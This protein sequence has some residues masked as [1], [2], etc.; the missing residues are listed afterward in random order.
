MTTEKEHTDPE[1]LTEDDL[2]KIEAGIGGLTDIKL[3]SVMVSGSAQA[4]DR[5]PR[6]PKTTLSD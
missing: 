2:N 4:R 6:K 1:E 5:E 3:T